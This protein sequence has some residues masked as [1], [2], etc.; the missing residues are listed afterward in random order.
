MRGKAVSPMWESE[1]PILP[2]VPDDQFWWLALVQLE[3]DARQKL[4]NEEEEGAYVWVA[5]I[6]KNQPDVDRLIRKAARAEGLRVVGIEDHQ[7]EEDLEEI[8]EA[9]EHLATDVLER[10]ENQRLSWGTWHVYY[11]DGEA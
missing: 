7:V 1:D 6:A 10:S 11:G 8:E 4:F 3:K 2:D 5:A 9:D